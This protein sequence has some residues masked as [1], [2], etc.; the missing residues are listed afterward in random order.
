MG[1]EAVR[2]ASKSSNCRM[3][4]ASSPRGR[5]GREE[6]GKQSDGCIRKKK[7]NFIL[8]TMGTFGRF[9]KRGNDQLGF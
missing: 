9:N 1:D 3:A 8:R 7:L 5:E 6:T 2:K 4:G